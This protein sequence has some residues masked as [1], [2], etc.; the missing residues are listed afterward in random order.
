MGK[1]YEGVKFETKIIEKEIPS[2]PR[3]E[4]LRYWCVLFH[5]QN[6]APPYPL[7]LPDKGWGSYGN[8]SFRVKKGENPFIITSSKSSLEHATSN[9]K[10]VLVQNIDYGNRSVYVHAKQGT[11]PSSEA[12]LH[13]S[14]YQKRPKVNAIFHGHCDIITN[15]A[16]SLGIPETKTKKPYGSMALVNEV[17]EVLGNYNFLQ[18]KDHGFLSL[19]KTI[20]E[21]G[22][23]TLEFLSKCR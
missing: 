10:F 7:L 17:L 8:L 13:D 14:I 11:D 1:G 18:M 15:N 6:L 2:D 21:A 4:R 9:D 5:Q 23:L 19:G 3:L 22:N 12:R 16:R 20:D